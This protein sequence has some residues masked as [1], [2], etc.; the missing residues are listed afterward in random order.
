MEVALRDISKLLPLAVVLAIF[1]VAIVWMLQREM[2]LG[3]WLL[4]AFLFGHGLVHIMFVTPPPA[5]PDSPAADFAFDPARS[6]L[7]T[8]GALSVSA[9]RAIVLGLVAVAV[10]GYGLT[11]LATVGLIVPATWWTALLIV[12]TAASALLMIVALMPGLALGVAIDLVLIW[13]AITAAWSPSG[14]TAV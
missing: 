13:V 10:V 7:V 8:S 12:T 1:G 2:A 5:T 11:A 14:V 3:T 9:V 6:W 4:A